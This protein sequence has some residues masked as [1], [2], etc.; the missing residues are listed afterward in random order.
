VSD[1]NFDKPLRLHDG[2]LVF[3]D[4]RV[5]RPDKEPERVVPL[6]TPAP[7]IKL[8]EVPTHAEARELVVNVRKKLSDLPEVPRTMNAVSAVLAYSLFGLDDDEIAV[9]VSTTVDRVRAIRE[10]PAF[11]A[12]RNDIVANVLDAEK[13]EVRELFAKHAREATT[14]VISVMRNGK[15]SDRLKA[16]A[17]VLDR[18]GFRPA[19][20]VEHH[21]KMEGG[22]SIEIIR[23]ETAPTI[24]IDM[25]TEN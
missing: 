19:D 16:A 14:Q 20:V 25:S 3:K 7:K 10:L 6:S 17:D 5:V 9:A 24:N 8:V 1:D 4:G 18:S 15:A 11:T 21:H 12:M 22:L 13:G 2:T 23:R